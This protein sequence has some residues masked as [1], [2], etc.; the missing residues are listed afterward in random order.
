MLT[1]KIMKTYISIIAG[2]LVFSASILGQ[3]V[4][5]TGSAPKD[6][7]VNKTNPIN[8]EKFDPTRDPRSDLDNAVA[9]A[10]KN[11]KHIILDVG[12][13]WCGWCVFMDKFFVQNPELA[14]L[15]DESFVWVKVNF[16]EENKNTM[17]LSSFPARA[18]YPHLYVLD[19]TGKLLH[20][21]D[22]SV[23]EKGK[24]YDLDKFMAFLRTWSPKR[25]PIS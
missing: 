1:M 23:L 10:S 22:T 18:G 6:A 12:G 7:S 19:A 2:V 17:F 13:E 20:S 5:P 8:R 14:K 3:A 24:G 25:K 21:E 11:G 15:R 9:Q 16:S 4:A